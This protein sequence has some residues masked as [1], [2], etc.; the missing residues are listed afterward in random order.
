MH[1]TS[2]YN[3]ICVLL[4]FVV[5]KGRLDGQVGR[6]FECR[7][8]GVQIHGRVTEKLAPA[9]FLVSVHHLRP[10]AGLVGPVSV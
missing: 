6:A 7:R 9:A 4:M 2:V 5:I 1:S 8:S 10:R 3:T